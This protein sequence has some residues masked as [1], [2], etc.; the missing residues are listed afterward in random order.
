MKCIL[1]YIIC[2]NMFQVI[3]YYVVASHIF[4]YYLCINKTLND[5]MIVC[6][7]GISTLNVLRRNIFYYI[8]V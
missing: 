8:C 6:S 3:S 5:N 7:D 4:A 1:S 2:V